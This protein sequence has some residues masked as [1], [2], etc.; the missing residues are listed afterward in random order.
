MQ[1]D[2]QEDAVSD[3]PEC[4]ELRLALSESQRKL[5]ACYSDRLRIRQDLISEMARPVFTRQDL[6]RLQAQAIDA[7]IE[8]KY[9]W[10][11]PP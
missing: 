9:P 11:E 3:R 6:D 10:P 8:A 4:Q 2:Q 1:G 7:K 5:R